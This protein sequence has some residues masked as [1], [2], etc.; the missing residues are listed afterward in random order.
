M[1]TPYTK[2]FRGVPNRYT[3]DST[4]RRI[5]VKPGGRKYIGIKRLRTEISNL[6]RILERGRISTLDVMSYIMSYNLNPLS[7]AL[8]RIR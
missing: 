4:E 5:I 6:I 7:I 3:E 2:G 8:Q 1:T